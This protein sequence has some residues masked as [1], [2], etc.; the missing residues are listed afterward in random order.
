MASYGVSSSRCYVVWN[1][2]KDEYGGTNGGHENP[3]RDHIQTPHH[4]EQYQRGKGALEQIVLLVL[5]KIRVDDVELY[6]IR[7]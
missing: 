4:D 2:E 5:P 3:V 7:L 6:S 1:R